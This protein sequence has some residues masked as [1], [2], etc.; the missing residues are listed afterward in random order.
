LGSWLAFGLSGAFA[1]RAPTPD[2]VKVAAAYG[3]LPL[4]FEPN[5]GQTDARVKFL[6][7]G[8]G[9]TFSL[10]PT[11]GVFGLRAATEKRQGRLRSQGP[12]P[13]E[14]TVVRMKLAGANPTAEMRAVEPLP[15]KSNYFIGNDPS[16]WRTVIPNYRKVEAR[17]VYPGVDLDYY[18]T[19][20]QLEFDFIVQ[21]GGNPDTIRML[22]E[23]GKQPHIDDY[24]DLVVST[25][26]GEIRQHKPRVYQEANGERH[27]IDGRFVLKGRGQVGFEVLHYDRSRRLVIDPML[28]YSTYLGGSLED[29]ASAIAVDGSG[30]AY[31]VGRTASTNFPTASPFQAANAGGGL[32]A[33][34]TK[35][36]AAGSALIYSTYLGGASGPEDAF[37]IAVDT[38]GNAYVAGATGSTDFPTVNPLQAANGG[39]VNDA[40]VAKLNASGSALIYSTYLGGSLADTAS[41]IAI[42]AAGNA[43]VG[44]FTA[45]TN[46]PTASPLQAASGGGPGDAFVAK[47]NAAGSALVYS[48]YLGGSGSD[49]VSGIAVDGAGNMF[50]AGETSSTDFPTA[51]PLQAVYGGGGDAFVTKLNAAG[52]ALI[53]STYLGGSLLDRP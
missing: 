40:F 10:T 2:A 36:N 25:S 9:Y 53:Y 38:A 17:G 24:G 27:A 47:L 51:S 26:L 48:T 1:A 15:G 16:H 29:L 37:G 35:L 30:N 3:N 12:Q 11:E 33:F 44:G 7:R 5:Q 43:Y 23:G 21:P 4:S 41:G 28:V 45:S 34:V 22:F 50:V 42:D 32:D 20:R 8:P 14:S 6:S 13:V 49:R 18:G 46:F 31:V 52:S 39:G 19:G